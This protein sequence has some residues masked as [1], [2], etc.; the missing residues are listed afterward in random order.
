MWNSNLN[1]AALQ[2]SQ[3]VIWLKKTDEKTLLNL[4]SVNSNYHTKKV[5][6]DTNPEILILTVKEMK[7]Q[8]KQQRRDNPG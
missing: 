2:Y 1:L 6:I 7:S 8:F 3:T 4:L 5:L